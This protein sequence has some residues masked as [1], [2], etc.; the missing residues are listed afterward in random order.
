MHV[1]DITR[2]ALS[3]HNINIIA[4]I[5]SKATNQHYCRDYFQSYK[6]IQSTRFR[7]QGRSRC[8]S[9]DLLRECF[10]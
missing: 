8:F 3:K 1:P 7:R 5:T 4:E 10:R 6:L 2:N 9:S